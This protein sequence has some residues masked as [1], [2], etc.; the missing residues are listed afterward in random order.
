MTP[1]LKTEIDDRYGSRRLVGGSSAED[2]HAYFREQY[3]E[4]VQVGQKGVDIKRSLDGGDEAAAQARW[5]SQTLF[6]D[7]AWLIETHAPGRRVLDAGCGTGDLLSEL[8]RLGFE[9]EGIELAPAALQAARAKGHTVHSGAFEDLDPEARFDA[10][11]FMHVL[12]HAAQPQA[13]LEHARK[14]LTPG[15][16]IIIRS[17]N[18]FNA[19]QDVLAR[20]LA[21]GEYWVTADHQ[22]Y[23]DFASAGRLMSAAG[24]DPVY[25]QSD[26]PMEMLA[27]MG[28]DFIGDSS[29]GKPAHDQ[30]VRF[31]QTVPAE[32]RR[33]LYRAFAQ[34]GLGRCILMA[35]RAR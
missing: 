34:A 32:T 8:S 27:L 21:H 22:H 18:D 9:A 29:L 1:P 20:E 30:R 19:L 23:F 16:L 15:G 33:K 2:V 17:G 11:T 35:G 3:Y 14:L 31:E 28:Q 13:M 12:S 24:F 25:S 10:V 26:F 5:M 7:I 6:A 4:A